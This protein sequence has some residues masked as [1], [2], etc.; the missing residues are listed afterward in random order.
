MTL[1]VNNDVDVEGSMLC[2]RRVDVAVGSWRVRCGPHGEF[3]GSPVF[4]S[5]AYLIGR[6]RKLL[7]PRKC[8]RSKEMRKRGTTDEMTDKRTTDMQ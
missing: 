4:N 7:C 5:T 6:K 3:F 2:V 1:L 8:E